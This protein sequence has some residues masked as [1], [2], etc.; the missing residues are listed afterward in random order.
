VSERVA[1]MSRRDFVAETPPADDSIEFK[2]ESDPKRDPNSD[3]R[4]ALM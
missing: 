1:A 2:C 3:D 4:K